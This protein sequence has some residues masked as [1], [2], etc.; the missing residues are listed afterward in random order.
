MSKLRGSGRRGGVDA[1]AG[2]NSGTTGGT[3]TGLNAGASNG[4]N[5]GIIGGF[6]KEVLKSRDKVLTKMTRDGVVEQ[7]MATKEETRIS[8]RD[9][10]FNLRKNQSEVNTDDSANT[11]N[12]NGYGAIGDNSYNP[13]ANE[14]SVKPG[15]QVA[16]VSNESS[17][18]VGIK[19]NRHDAENANAPTN[20]EKAARIR[21]KQ[22]LSKGNNSGNET[23]QTPSAQTPGSSDNVIPS[24]P[25]KPLPVGSRAAVYDFSDIA[26]DDSNADDVGDSTITD[27]TNINHETT[28]QSKLKPALDDSSRPK[29]RITHKS[30]TPTALN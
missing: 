17:S 22:E 10:G 1:N 23:V 26:D 18:Q 20:K 3:N 13:N 16:N 27:S 25:N 19:L 9:V 4:T 14:T 8:K 21:R 29:D 7:N 15:N 28:R 12:A 30:K 5:D 24:Q 6:D 11:D 2:G